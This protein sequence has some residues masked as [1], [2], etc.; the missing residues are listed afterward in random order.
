MYIVFCT[1]YIIYF[2]TIAAVDGDPL[3]DARGRNVH[4]IVPHS[5]VHGNIYGS[6]HGIVV[7]RKMS[8]AGSVKVNGQLIVQEN[9]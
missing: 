4:V 6:V 2:S 5:N 1:L 3:E 7:S 8:I 9:T